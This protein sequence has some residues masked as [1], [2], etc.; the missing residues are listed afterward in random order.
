MRQATHETVFEPLM[1]GAIK[2][3]S[4]H[5][6]RRDL[7]CEPRQTNNKDCRDGLRRS[8]AC[9]P[10]CCH[11]ALFIIGP[12]CWR[13]PSGL[14]RSQRRDQQSAPFGLACC[15]LEP[16]PKG[17]GRSGFVTAK[18]HHTWSRRRRPLLLRGNG[19]HSVRPA[20]VGSVP[21]TTLLG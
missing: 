21:S 14:P 6:L 2:L 5:S 16:G 8:S 17:C 4:T 13:F 9:M 20:A 19:W 18:L 10:Y 3:K 12:S 15:K 7:H 11:H 1:S